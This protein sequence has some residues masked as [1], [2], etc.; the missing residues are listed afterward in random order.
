MLDADAVQRII[1]HM[2]DD[3]ADAVLLYVQAFAERPQ[4]GEAKMIAIDSHGMDIEY[5]EGENELSCRVAFAKP[6]AHAG[7]AREVLVAMVRQAR[8]KLTG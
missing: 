5:L 6:L 3:H 7:E 1:S 2:N 8:D 4:A